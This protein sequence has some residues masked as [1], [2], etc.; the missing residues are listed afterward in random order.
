MAISREYA[1]YVEELLSPLGAV[2]VCSMFGGSGVYLDGVMFGL[3]AD[4]VLYFKADDTSKAAFADEGME[5]FVYDGK[6]KSMTMPYWQVPERLFDEPDE[7]ISSARIALE[8]ARK[9]KK[10]KRA[11]PRKPTSSGR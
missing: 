9:S 3:I 2:S 7:L 10:A 1:T 5:A 4:E 11:G 8:V 6:G